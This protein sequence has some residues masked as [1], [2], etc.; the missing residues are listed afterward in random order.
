MYS[1]EPIRKSCSRFNAFDTVNA[2]L[3]SDA[4]PYDI[5]RLPNS[6]MR[7]ELSVVL[8]EANCLP[9]IC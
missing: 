1:K 3:P 5:S 4:G 6:G 8:K 7:L 9:N 2:A